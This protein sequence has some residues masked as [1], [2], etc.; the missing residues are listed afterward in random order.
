M[1]SA[2][3]IPGG[4]TLKPDRRLLYLLSASVLLHG[5]ILTLPGSHGNRSLSD[6]MALPIQASIRVPGPQP[7]RRFAE[8]STAEPGTA[9][10]PPPRPMTKTWVAPLPESDTS[11]RSSFNLENL[12]EQARSLA[13]EA[14]DQYL[15]GTNSLRQAATPDLI[16]RPILDALSKRLGQPLRVMSEQILNDGSRFIRFAGNTCL[17]I[18][19]HLTFVRASKFTQTILLPTNCP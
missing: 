8:S 6:R 15:R 13:K 2:W 11:A 16:D 1:H 19:Q 5:L 9:H 17:H 10:K 4:P 18:P 12:R 3:D 14:P 7:E